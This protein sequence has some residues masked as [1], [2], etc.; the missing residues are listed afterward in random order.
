[1]VRLIDDPDMTL[2]VY[3][4]RKTANQQQQHFIIS[5]KVSM[6]INIYLHVKVVFSYTDSV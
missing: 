1:M 3:G 2:D 5:A 4:G 6:K